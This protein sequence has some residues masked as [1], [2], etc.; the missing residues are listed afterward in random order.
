MNNPD[1]SDLQLA[2]KKLYEYLPQ[3]TLPKS[4]NKQTTKEVLLDVNSRAKNIYRSK[5]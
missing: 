5:I 4:L 2:E 3:P 1:H